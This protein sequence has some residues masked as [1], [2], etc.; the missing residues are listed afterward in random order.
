MLQVS[1]ED[2]NHNASIVHVRATV[3]MSAHQEK[4]CQL[5]TRLLRSTALGT[6]GA[7]KMPSWVRKD[8]IRVDIGENLEYSSVI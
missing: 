8:I 7:Y 1:C 5:T 6:S 3:K 4:A 2:H